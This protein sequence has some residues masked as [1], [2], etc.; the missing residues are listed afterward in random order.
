MS[1]RTPLPM[2]SGSP[3]TER[4]E[5]CERLGGGAMGLVYR[6]LDRETGREV[7]LK[8]LRIPDAE[9]I[10]RLKR[11][12][13]A[14]ADISHPHLVELLD[15]VVTGEQCFF[16]MELVRGTGLVEALRGAG[17]GDPDAVRR[18][19]WQLALGVQALHRAGK[20]HRDIKPGNVMMA[21]GGRVVLMDFGLATGFDTRLSMRSM[22][23]ALAGTFQYMSP[24]QAWGQTL[25]TASDWYAAGVVLYEVLT[26]RA[27]FADLSPADLVGPRAEPTIPPRGWVPGVPGDLD[28]LAM[29]LLAP[30]PT[31]RPSEEEILR[32]LQPAPV[33]RLPALDTVPRSAR[34]LVGRHGE[35]HR[36][37]QCFE[38]AALGES[39]VVT[40]EGESG[41]GKT[42]LLERFAHEIETGGRGFVLRSRCHLREEVTFKA[43]DA[44]VDELSRLLVDLDAA[45]LQ[46][47]MPAGVGALLR[48]FP[49]LARVPFRLSEVDHF[50]KAE[51]LEL[52]R[53]AFQ[54]LRELL[55]AVAGRQ[56]LVLWIDDY[57]WSD[58]DS[59][60]LLRDLLRGPG[61]PAALWLLAVRSGDPTSKHWTQALDAVEHRRLARVRLGPLGRQEVQSLAWALASEASLPPTLLAAVEREAGG[62]PFLVEE[63]VRHR[64]SAVALDGEPLTL[65]G[66]VAARVAGLASSARR[67]LET[68]AIA[69]G[70]LAR[71]VALEA[72]DAAG[73]PGA[74]AELE[75]LH[76]VRPGLSDGRATLEPHH[77]RIRE[78]VEA[79]LS[80]A[81]RRA[82]HGGL[83]DVLSR[84]PDADPL[85]LHVHCLGAGRKTE[86]AAHAR[87]AA[88]RAASQLAFEQAA[89]LYAR[90]LELMPDA[91]RAHDL[92]RGL[93][94]ALANAG[95]GREAAEVFT[96]AIAAAERAGASRWETL[97][98]RRRAAEQ[99]LVSG[100]V[101][102]GVG[103]LRPLLREVGVPYPARAGGAL[104]AALVGLAR[105]RLRGL[106]FSPC[107]EA[108]ATFGD[109]VRIDACHTAAKG[110]LLVDP[111][112][113]AFFSVETLRR[114]LSAGEVGRVGRGFCVVGAALLPAG[115]A[116]SRFAERM[117]AAAQR[118]AEREGDP[119]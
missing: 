36:L 58:P 90:A 92:Q 77:A 71:D 31:E 1:S 100:Y 48:V 67:I 109:L 27:P 104:A 62:S 107:D 47:L 102:S 110:L 15:L 112:R 63:L 7:A 16:T 61:A 12:F 70:P 106:R 40:V 23:G 35:L 51:P 82:R 96:G 86:A 14:F 65:P 75:R 6:A 54:A 39:V 103:A 49:V 89:S 28:A 115:G 21:D 17:A 116:V 101:E 118:L 111:A 29:A 59:A 113:G 57:Q 33:G 18:A 60:L 50:L 91:E 98:L 13:R 24:E 9:E 20:L 95:R 37:R 76:L 114:A 85:V 55:G 64:Q 105:L 45:E 99:Y 97:M 26:G 83:A 108:E 5:L 52:R 68:V 84:R 87:R 46:A 53:Q 19:F 74:V 11:E 44:L 34:P 43:V 80:D 81:R 88:A 22:T 25:S 94:E 79:A 4:Y 117:I 93:G 78:A 69:S 2:L 30:E 42:S 8:T 32:V 10:F 56:H 73:D 38:R 66:I 72:A 119:Y 3:V 41:I